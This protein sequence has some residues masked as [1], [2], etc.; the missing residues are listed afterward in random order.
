MMKPIIIPT[1]ITAIMD[2]M[3]IAIIVISCITYTYSVKLMQTTCVHAYNCSDCDRIWENVHSSH[4][5]FCAFKVSSNMIGKAERCHICCTDRGIVAL[6]SLQVSCLSDMYNRFYESSKLKKWMCELCT[7]S[8]IRSLLCT[9]KGSAI[10]YTTKFN[11]VISY[12]YT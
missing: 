9:W 7:F 8:Q 3:I 10:K 6:Q 5:R 12:T 4:I 11:L 2:E 1:I